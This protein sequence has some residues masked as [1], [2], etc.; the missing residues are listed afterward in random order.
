M[1]VFSSELG[2]L[3]DALD[4]DG[5]IVAP[6]PVGYVA[7]ASSAAGVDR[8]FELKGR[9]RSR[10]LSVAGTADREGRLFLEELSQLTATALSTLRATMGLVGTR[11][12]AATDIPDGVGT[13]NSLAVFVGLGPVLEALILR[14]RSVGRSLFVTSANAS[15]AG[16]AVMARQLPKALRSDAVA[17]LIDDA[18]IPESQ[19]HLRPAPASP[20]VRLGPRPTLIRQGF[21]QR[22]VLDQLA[23]AGIAVTASGCLLPSERAITLI[24]PQF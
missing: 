22:V 9:D 15:G 21:Q 19:R 8:I 16:N 24:G 2:P 17:A 1:S 3:F 18:R 14:Q 20:M 10:P 6:C 23:S 7:A 13:A 4:R 5:V 11:R 12:D